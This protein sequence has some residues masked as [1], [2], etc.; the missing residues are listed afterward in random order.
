MNN[1]RFPSVHHPMKKRLGLG[2]LGV[3]FAVLTLP[4]S[5]DDYG[6]YHH[7]YHHHHHPYDSRND[8]GYGYHRHRHHHHDDDRPTISVRVPD[9]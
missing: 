5:A 6:Q 7:R 3:V 1:F 4:A 9:L 2:L 8:D